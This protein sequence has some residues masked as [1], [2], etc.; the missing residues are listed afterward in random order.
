[1][2]SLP[3]E[4][5]ICVSRKGTDCDGGERVNLILGWR[6]LRYGPRDAP[7]ASSSKMAMMS[8]MYLLSQRVHIYTEGIYILLWL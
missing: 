2:C 6:E 7:A 4:K 1:M 5:C 8:S 3:S